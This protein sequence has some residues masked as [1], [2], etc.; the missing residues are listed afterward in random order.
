MVNSTVVLVIVGLHDRLDLLDLSR[1]KGLGSILGCS[2]AQGPSS[3][4]LGIRAYFPTS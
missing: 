2:F 3:S 4:F 1:N